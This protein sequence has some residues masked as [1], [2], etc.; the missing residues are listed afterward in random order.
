M[1]QRTGSLDLI[2]NDIVLE[3]LLMQAAALNKDDNTND[4]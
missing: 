3:D 2:D 4:T 1:F